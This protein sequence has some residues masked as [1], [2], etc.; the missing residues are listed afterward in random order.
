MGQKVNSN[1]F[2]LGLTNNLQWKSKYIEK[3]FEEST[4]YIYKDCKIQNYL[5][6]ILKIHGL[7]LHD[8]KI[9]YSE[10]CIAIYISYYVLTTTKKSFNKNSAELK[11]LF[12]QI[13]ICINLF[14]KKQYI[15]KIRIK[16]QNLNEKYKNNLEAIF[17]KRIEKLR[18][19]KNNLIFKELLYITLITTIEQNSS[20]LLTE[21]IT[22]QFQKV[23]KRHG[24]LL[25]MMKAILLQFISSKF[26]KITGLKLS[27]K[28]RF[29]GALRANQKII[30]LGAVPLQTITS[31]VN[32]TQSVAFT[33]N[34][35]FGIKVWICEK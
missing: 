20:K 31:K 25:S 11:L 21:Y 24:F 12:D 6:Q 3:N 10:T 34:G 9:W 30:Q 22:I 23:K 16:S 28:G 15:T 8:C 2:R 27:I 19:F 14:F 7:L 17:Q 4:L 35:T 29:N 13:L 5:K 32:Y 26:S 1:I 33:K 18:K